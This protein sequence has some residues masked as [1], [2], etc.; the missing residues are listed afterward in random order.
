MEADNQFVTACSVIDLP[1]VEK[2][3]ADGHVS[4]RLI[5]R[6]FLKAASRD[7]PQLMKYLHSVIIFD[8]ETINHA[9][10]AAFM[11]GK[12][13]SL[14]WFVSINADI[15]F[16]EGALFQTLCK[17]GR[18]EDAQFIYGLGGTD[19]HARCNGA[20]HHAMRAR[21]FP[22]VEWLLT[23]DT[24]ETWPLTNVYMAMIRNYRLRRKWWKKWIYKRSTRHYISI[25][26]ME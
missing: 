23:L 7:H 21:Q 18:L 6:A 5:Q 19:I 14:R 25:R 4:Q 3:L 10:Q 11:A 15:Y 1:T 9:L 22:V 26:L 16:S 17:L 20:F 13:D 2:L 8:Q 24:A 12:F